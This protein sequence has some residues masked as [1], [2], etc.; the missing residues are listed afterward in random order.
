MGWYLI[1]IIFIGIRVPKSWQKQGME[2]FN[3][4]IKELLKTISKII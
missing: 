1:I 2:N 4:K 3:N